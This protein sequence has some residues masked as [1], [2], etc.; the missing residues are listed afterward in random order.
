MFLMLLVSSTL[1]IFADG[2]P[3]VATFEELE[4]PADGHISVSTEEDD[5]RTEFVSGGYVFMQGMTRLED[6]LS[7]AQDIDLQ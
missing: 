7:E 5:E 4:V 6:I 1:F 3:A 2:T